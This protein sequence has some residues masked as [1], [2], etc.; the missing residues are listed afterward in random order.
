MK[1]LLAA[2]LLA[3]TG[4]AVAQGVPTIDIGPSCRA[5]AKGSVGM[6]QDYE[7]CRNSEAAARES[8]AKQWSTFLPADRGSCYRLTTTGTPGTY[9]EFLTCLEMKRDARKLPDT[10][11][12]QG[13]RR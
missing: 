8:L 7:S 4:I 11:I 3:S 9:T 10:T 6:Q 5:A 1:S 2:L 13:G 12:G